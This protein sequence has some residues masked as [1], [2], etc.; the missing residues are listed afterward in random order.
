MHNKKNLPF[1]P[2]ICLG[3]CVNW[4]T[5]LGL[6]RVLDSWAYLRGTGVS[7]EGWMV[8]TW[9]LRWSDSDVVAS[10]SH[11]ARRW[12]SPGPAGAAQTGAVIHHLLRWWLSKPSPETY[13]INS[14]SSFGIW[15]CVSPFMF[16]YCTCWQLK[17]TEFLH[18]CRSDEIDNITHMHINLA[19]TIKPSIHIKFWLDHYLF[20]G[21][22][23]KTR[24]HSPIFARYIF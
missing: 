5:C 24:P 7:K 3:V 11:R 17:W 13:G 10:A 4:K 6:R 22:I 23:F 1:D 2:L 20:Y 18:A 15:Y 9:R 19:I 16:N 12:C 14:Y 21:K 8:P